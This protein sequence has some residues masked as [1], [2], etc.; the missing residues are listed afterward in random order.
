MKF[1]FFKKLSINNQKGDISI[2]LALMVMTLIFALAMG[3][4]AV[5]FEEIRMI[6]RVERSIIAFYA[7]DTGIEKGLV[8][9][10][11]CKRVEGEIEIPDECKGVLNPDKP[12]Y[13][14]IS[15][16]VEYFTPVKP[17][18][19]HIISKGEFMGTTRAI[20]LIREGF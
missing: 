3:L 1:K 14:Q 5:I 19:L 9:K 8:Y 6:R 18:I 7:A 15:Y 20:K 11:K 13:R 17:I 16:E 2:L 10:E 12:L 4:S